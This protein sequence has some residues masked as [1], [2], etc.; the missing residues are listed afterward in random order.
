MP[1]EFIQAVIDALGL[2]SMYALVALG[3]ALVFGVMR[4]I[5]FAYGDI[6]VGAAYAAYFARDLG[7]VVVF[8]AML[9]AGIG[10]SLAT[11]RVAFRPLRKADPTSMLIASFAVSAAIQNTALATVGSAPRGIG[12]GDFLVGAFS[13]GSVRVPYYTFFAIIVVVVAVIALREFLTRTS[14]GIAMRAA[15]E[16]FTA[17]RL[18]GVRANKVIVLAFGISG[19]LASIVSLFLVAQTGVVAPTSATAPALLGFVA[20]VVG[21][22]GS[23]MAAALGGLLL[24]VMQV[25]LQY[26][27]P[28][29]LL[30]FKDALLFGAVLL[31]L[32][33]VPQ[34]LFVRSD[35][36]TTRL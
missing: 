16:D 7:M 28:V 26:A 9:A 19:A 23:L 13:W 8:A 18:I 20:V 21:G 15:S 5:N 29:D 6:I 24:G 14:S 31:I 11:E 1:T 25:V 36:W 10:I 32:V 17:A 22:M 30:V 34:G 2:G 33:L 12:A 3:I 35:P 4:L 27:L